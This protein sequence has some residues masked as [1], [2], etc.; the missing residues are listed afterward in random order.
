MKN[1]KATNWPPPFATM[2]LIYS[3]SW[4]DHTNKIDGIGPIYCP[5]NY[6]NGICACNLT[7]KT[8]P[9]YDECMAA[10]HP[11]TEWL[12]WQEGKQ[13]VLSFLR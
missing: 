13:G 7:R 2:A 12:H 11:I 1:V 6:Y 5:P 4:D 10:S 8:M 3:L 9:F